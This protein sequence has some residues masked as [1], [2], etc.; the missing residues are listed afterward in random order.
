MEGGEKEGGKE[1]G[2]GVIF[3]RKMSWFLV[4]TFTYFLSHPNVC[5]STIYNSQ[6]V[7]AMQ[8]LRINR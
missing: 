1:R 7:E 6:D 4:G 5:C 2:K 3:S 8:M